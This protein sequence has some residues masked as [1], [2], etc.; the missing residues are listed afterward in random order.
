M[1]R[2]LASLR[3]EGRIESRI[4]SGHY[5]ASPKIQKDLTDLLSFTCW[6]RSMGMEPG[7]RVLS[8]ECLE[9]SEA[10]SVSLRIPLGARTFHLVRLRLLDGAPVLL[11]YVYL[12]EEAYPGLIDCDLSSSSLYA[13]LTERY[14]AELFQG[15][16]TISVTYLDE[17]EACHLGGC[18]GNPAFFVRSVVSDRKGNPVEYCKTVIRGDKVRFACRHGGWNAGTQR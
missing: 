8:R 13:I 2:A 5:I 7:S 6:G 14:G 16:E 15:Q 11:E 12:S 3:L 4:G 1:R 10:V 17:W 18:V 9:A